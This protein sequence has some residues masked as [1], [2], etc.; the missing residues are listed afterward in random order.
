MIKKGNRAEL[1]M[2]TDKEA[3]Y[4]RKC[5]M[6]VKM[7]RANK[8]YNQYDL[9]GEYGIGFPTNDPNKPFY[10]DMEDYDKIKDY[11]WYLHYPSKDSPTYVTLI[12]YDSNSKKRIKFWWVVFGKNVDHINN[13][14]LDNRKENLRE[15]TPHQNSMNLKVKSN[16]RTGVIGVCACGSKWRSRIMFNKK[17]IPFGYYENFDDAVRARLIGEYKY[18]GE[19][20]PQKHLW[21]QYGLTEEG[22]KNAA[23]K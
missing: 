4:L 8:R 23:S 14:T 18:F 13:N 7:G 10:F 22:V 5:E 3:W 6:A 2:G 9:S 21:E 19:F 17:E 15:C 1:Y 11:C 16:N 12:A 20:A